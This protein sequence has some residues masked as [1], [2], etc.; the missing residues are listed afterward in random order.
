MNETHLRAVFL[1]LAGKSVAAVSEEF[2]ICRASLY[3]LRRRATDA[4]RREIEC[5][6]KNKNP[7]H[8]RIP[9]EKED[10]IVRLCQ[11]HTALSSYRISRKFQQL[12]NE[13]IN[14]RT[15]QRIRKRYFL[16]RVPQRP[17]PTFKAHRFTDGEKLIVRQIIKDKMFL[18]GER[19]AWDICNQYGIFVSPSTA[20]RI[21]QSILREIN[22]PPPKPN[23]RFYQRNHP[24]RLWHGDLME[25]V[26]LTD[27]NRTAFQ[28]TLLDDYSRAYV[29]CD[30]FREVTVNTTIKAMIAAMR[31]YKTIPQAAVFDNGSYFKGKLL[32]EFCR[33]LDIR[34]IHSAVNHPQTNGKLERAFR[35]DMNEFYKRFERWKFQPLKRKLPEYVNYRN[36]I[37]GHF[38]LE[39]KPS[40]VRLNK[41]DFFA[42]PLILN[43]LEKFAWCWRGEKKVGQYG[44]MRFFQRNVYINPKLA[45]QR[46][47]IFE[48]LDGL[49]A[50]DRTGKL[51]F[52]PEY[53]ECICR[54]FWQFNAGAWQD[55][56]RVYYFRPIRR[57]KRLEALN[58]MFRV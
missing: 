58:Q 42:L 11:R 31:K 47:K 4:V 38:A 51:Y 5:P 53:K 39:G 2:K 55:E 14:P 20:K 15:V 44:L 13:A 12:E 56:T 46:I 28:L 50:E 8:N 9:Q 19:L 25:K 16:P 7:S 17:A 22:P 23:W 36:E 21:K 6:T 57:S 37:R 24:H 26:T 18:G 33:R 54:P 52:L 49:E 27:E 40:A 30:L 48:T 32:Q 3:N 35:D 34:L 41:Q 45:A 1:M 10:K 43:N 29:F